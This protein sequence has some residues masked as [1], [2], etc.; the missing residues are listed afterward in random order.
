LVGLLK[1][2]NDLL[3]QSDIINSFCDESDADTLLPCPS[4]PANPMDVIF[5]LLGEIVVDN[6]ADIFDVQSSGS[7]IRSADKPC[8]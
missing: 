2:F 4:C 5:Y 1:Y 6:V 3:C 7:E 8:L